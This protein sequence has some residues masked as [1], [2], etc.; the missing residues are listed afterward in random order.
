MQLGRQSTF[1]TSDY[2]NKDNVSLHHYIIV[3]EFHYLLKCPIFEHTNVYFYTLFCKEETLKS[4]PV[5]N[6]LSL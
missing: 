2:V 3:D 4:G 6:Y 1:S 5:L